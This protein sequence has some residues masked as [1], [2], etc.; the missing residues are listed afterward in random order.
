MVND[1]SPIIKPINKS[2][3]NQCWE[4]LKTHNLGNRGIYDGDKVKQFIGLL[5][6]MESH[7]LLKG[8]YYNLEET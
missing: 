3:K 5:A 4:Y 2:I 1:Y 6:E 8:Y 7:M